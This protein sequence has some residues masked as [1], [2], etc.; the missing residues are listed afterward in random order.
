[1]TGPRRRKLVIAHRG[2]SGYLPEHTRE[3]K[4]LAYGQGADYLEQDVVATRDGV[5]VVLHDI[6]LDDV[7]DVARRYPARRRPDGRFYVIDFDFEEVARLRLE[8]RRRPGSA[9]RLYP[10][11]FGDDG[12]EFRVVALDEEL[13]LIRELNRET[14]RSVG[15]Y[16][17]IKR[18]DWHHAHGVDLAA[19]L[20]AEL[21]RHG[22]RCAADAAFVQCFDPAELERCRH[23]LGT[24][25]RLVQL[26]ES[27]A[28]SEVM[29]NA[30]GLEE[31]A[32]YADVIAPGFARIGEPAADGSLRLAPWVDALRPAGLDLHAFTFRRER[33]PPG[34]ASLE[35]LLDL[36]LPCL[37]GVFCDQPDV[38]VAARDRLG[39]RSR[40]TGPAQLP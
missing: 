8:E 26:V 28:Q 10:D 19:L 12:L 14:G 38:A 11:R 18:P 3:A 17:E 9:E 30:R 7:S 33:L 16:P 22:Y 37:D 21:D 40:W 24:R 32:S 13:R 25:L 36:F 6:H 2:A 4:V 27:G 15:I 5:L 20:L 34:V 1:M 31:I 29:L 39:S 23:G 35:A